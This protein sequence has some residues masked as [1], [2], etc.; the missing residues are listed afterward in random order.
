MWVLQEDEEFSSLIY[1]RM[2][3]TRLNRR[4]DNENCRDG[5]VMGMN[6]SKYEYVSL[7]ILTKQIE[8]RTLC[9]SR[10]AR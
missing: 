2:L 1:I 9:T 6:S 3:T 5:L 4:P 7:E 10:V 8:V